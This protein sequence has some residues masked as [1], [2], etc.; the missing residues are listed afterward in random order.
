MN[1]PLLVNS[2][3][4]SALATTLAGAIGFAGALAIAGANPRSQRMLLLAAVIALALPPFLVTNTW[5]DLLGQ[6]GS[7]RRWLPLDL[8]SMGGVTWLLALLSWPI[9]TLLAL[10]AWSRLE[11][12]QLEIDPAL[13]G[14]ALIRWL[15]WPMAR[16]AVGQAALLTFVLTLNNFSVPVILQVPVFPEELWLALSTQL[17][18]ARAWAAG[19]PMIVAPVIVLL[20]LRRA[21]IAWPRT[22]P[23]AS[24]TA[25]RRQL[26]RGWFR[27]ASVA[28]VLLLIFS[29]G[30][31]LAQLTASS[32]TWAELPD[33]F[34]AAPKVV[35]TSFAFAA[36]AATSCVAVGFATSRL[37]LN[38]VCWLPFFIPGV[39][40]GHAAVTVFSGTI[41]QGTAL[42]VVLA[43]AARYFGVGWTGV[44][45]ALRSLDR[46]LTDAARLSGARGWTLLRHVHWPQIAPRVAAAWYVTYLLCLWDV[47]T[48]AL[49]YPPGG[50]TLA[51]R[52]F[53]FL[54]YGRHAQVNASCVILL[55]LALAPLVVWAVT[56][57]WSASMRARDGGGRRS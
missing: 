47:E 20:L 36:A 10:G 37:P 26:G 41:L 44:S 40:I 30:L 23:T 19:L 5:I 22:Q 45:L 42:L 49:I 25:F 50:E 13:R 32:R 27:T 52:I 7:L 48:L 54:H 17:D 1:W 9:T 53:N 33:L 15:L 8:Y 57:R 24:A 51:L 3:L 34:R 35:W 18:I 55:A 11:P 4:V 56:K 28:V 39:L 46:D 16:V 43:F 29:L 14:V 21:E 38:I 2:L 12:A 6:N 31:P